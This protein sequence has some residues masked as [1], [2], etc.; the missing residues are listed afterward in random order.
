M[1]RTSFRVNAQR[2]AMTLIE[3][4]IVVAILGALASLLI[5]R[6]MD[7]SRPARHAAI[8]E[9]IGELAKN[10]TYY[11]TT[12]QKAIPNRLDALTSDGTTPYTKLRKHI[13]GGNKRLAMA[14]VANDGSNLFFESMKKAGLTTVMY[15]D[16]ALT[17]TPSDS[18]TVP[19]TLAAGD[20]LPTLNTQTPEGLRLIAALFPGGIPATT[21]PIVLG[22]GPAN[23]AVGNSMLSAPMVPSDE[24]SSYQRYLVVYSL[25]ADGRHARLKAILDSHADPLNK[26]ITNLQVDL[27][28][29]E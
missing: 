10:L 29:E 11:Q 3:L 6:I 16:E 27:Q 7:M 28:K 24:P 9:T 14:P 1:N 2:R 13:F 21:H 26:F 17:S 23:A 4:V 20:T 22:V 5:P 25:Y 15:H 12:T 8:S 18:G 19:H